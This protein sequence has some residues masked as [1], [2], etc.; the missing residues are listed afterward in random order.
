MP[1]SEQIAA[2]LRKDS[3]RAWNS[4]TEREQQ[5]C[6]LSTKGF[7]RSKIANEMGITVAMVNK[8]RKSIQRQI[9]F[10]SDIYLK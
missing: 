8:L 3:E 10:R 7:S 6:K 2:G 1:T 9:G 5:L 4:L